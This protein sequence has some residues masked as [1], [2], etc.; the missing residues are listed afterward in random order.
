MSI[1]VSLLKV[2]SLIVK[3]FITIMK[4]CVSRKL[5]KVFWNGITSLAESLISW[6]RLLKVFIAEQYTPFWNFDRW[7]VGGCKL[8]VDFVC[9]MWI[10]LYKINVYFLPQILM[11]KGYI[12]TIMVVFPVL[13]RV[14]YTNRSVLSLWWF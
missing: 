3:I 14:P 11:W 6:G 7:A 10:Y 5:L 9:I 8:V 12:E 2:M 13:W 1:Q 4:D